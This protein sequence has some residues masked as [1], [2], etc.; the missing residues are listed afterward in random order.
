MILSA[1]A[2]LDWFAKTHDVAIDTLPALAE[3]ADAARAPLFLPYLSGERTPHNDANARGVFFGLA[4]EHRAGDLAYAAMEGVAFAFAMADGYAALRN[5][6]TTLDGA[7][8]IGGGS[9]SA[10][11]A[12]LCA[13]AT[14]SRCIGTRAARWARRSA[15]RGLRG[16]R[17]RAMRSTTGASRRR[18]RRR[19][20]PIRRRRICSARGLRGTDGCI[21]H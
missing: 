15:R 9:K 16:S 7:S 14:G 2:S 1:A 3:R 8:F 21:G 12:R 11:W 20:G 13:N 17:R 18:S 10:F 19:I 5:A 6:G 4:S